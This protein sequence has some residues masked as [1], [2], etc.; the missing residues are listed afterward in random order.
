MRKKTESQR[1]LAP[2]ILLKSGVVIFL[3]SCLSLVLLVA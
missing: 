3:F 2:V 1:R